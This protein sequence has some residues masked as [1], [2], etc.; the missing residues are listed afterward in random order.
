MKPFLFPT[1]F[2]RVHGD[3]TECPSCH[4]SWQGEE[5][6]AEH[7]HHYAKGRTHFSR[8]IGIEYRGVYDGVL[9]W[10][11]PHCKVEHPRFEASFYDDL[12]VL[13]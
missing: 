4:K 7:R 1:P 5:I 9:V 2:K 11:C 3:E 12:K 10:R 6:P 8:L 13:T